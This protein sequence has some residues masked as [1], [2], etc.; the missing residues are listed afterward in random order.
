MVQRYQLQMVDKQTIRRPKSVRFSDKEMAVITKFS[1]I[2]KISPADF[3][4][5]WTMYGSVLCE[6]FGRYGEDLSRFFEVGGWPISLRS[7]YHQAFNK[8]SIP[9]ETQ[10]F[11]RALVDSARSS[12]G[13]GADHEGSQAKGSKN[14]EGSNE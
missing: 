8:T 12:N 13:S 7:H 5:L 10:D 14:T 3:V 11:F 9:R 4:W 6:D 1:S 2:M